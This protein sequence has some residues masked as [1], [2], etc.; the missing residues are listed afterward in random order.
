VLRDPVA[1]WEVVAESDGDTVRL[2]E[3]VPVKDGETVCETLNDSE[4]ENV[5]VADSV[6]VEENEFVA[7]RD[8]E[9]DELL[10]PVIDAETVTLGL[11]VSDNDGDSVAEPVLVEDADTVG[12][13]D[14]VPVALPLTVLDHEAV[15]VGDPVTLLE[16]VGDALSDAECDNVLELVALTS[17]VCDSEILGDG[18]A[19]LLSELVS[20]GD[21]AVKV[22]V[23][24]VDRD[25]VGLTVNEVELDLEPVDVAESENVPVG[26]PLV[27][28][29]EGE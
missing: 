2:S 26:E 3:L 19:V 17:P 8:A 13:V 10:V 12:E 11:A 28:V 24:V 15:K 6:C 20:V 4:P 7:D 14:V 9:S 5:G 29:L 16:A 18:D 22:G 27:A 1:D 21:P 23:C 25:A